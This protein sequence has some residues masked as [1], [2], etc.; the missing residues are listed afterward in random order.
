MGWGDVVEDG[1]LGEGRKWQI[2]FRDTDL[3]VGDESDLLRL[4]WGSIWHPWDSKRGR[5]R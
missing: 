3:H 2:L 4:T 5:V 1:N